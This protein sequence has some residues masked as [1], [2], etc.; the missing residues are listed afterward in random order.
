MSETFELESFAYLSRFRC[1]GDKCEDTCCKGWGMQ[2][3]A[4]H[5]ELYKK[6]A[7]ELLD[8][9]TTGEAEHIMRRDPATDYCVKFEGGICSIHRDRGT[10][11]LGD[12]CHFYPRVTRGF[13]QKNMQSAALSCPEIVRIILRDEAPF[14]PATI[15][16]D[17]LPHAMKNYLPEGQ[18]IITGEHALSIQRHFIDAALD[19]SVPAERALMRIITVSHSL[20][21]LPPDKWAEMAGF[22]FRMADGR[23]MAAESNPLDGFRL[24]QILEALIGAAKPTARPYL[25]DTRSA[26]L[27]ALGIQIAA[28]TYDIVSRN[29]DFSTY[30]NLWQRYQPIARPRVDKLL[31]RW[32]AGQ[33]AMAGY[34]FGG[35]GAKLKDRAAVLAVRFATLRLALMAKMDAGGHPPAEETIVHTIHGLSRFL[36]HLADPAF[37]LMAYQEAGWLSAARLRGLIRDE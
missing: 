17:R 10:N 33:L 36:D 28:N 2:V 13:A 20:E 7:P 9:V 35:F 24:A 3:D 8:A 5:V 4:P 23:L 25:D 30:E 21:T 22:L 15:T 32:L 37:S 12:A 1:I 29:G 16:T 14:A 27:E 19:E 26:M 31:K 11:F 6:E 34:P 18:D